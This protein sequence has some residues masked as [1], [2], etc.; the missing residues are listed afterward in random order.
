MSPTLLERLV[1]ELQH[2][3]GPRS[4]D[5]TST[6]LGDSVRRHLARL[7]NTR[8]DTAQACPTYGLPDLRRDME[9]AL[10][11]RAVLEDKI[12]DRIC[13][14]EPR[15]RR[16]DLQ[17]SYLGRG[18][19]PFIAHFQI[20]GRLLERSRVGT[21]ARGVLDVQTRHDEEGL[22]LVERADKPPGGKR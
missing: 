20:S 7:L 10:V 12:K 11:Q 22:V 19:S 21:L 8:D 14:Y 16:E 5:S 1:P 17:V 3:D 2:E 9:A 15:L 18:R 4:R 6:P 13:E